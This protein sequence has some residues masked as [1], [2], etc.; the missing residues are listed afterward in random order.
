MTLLTPFR[1]ILIRHRAKALYDVFLP[2]VFGVGLSVLLLA[3]KR[4]VPIFGDK[5]YLS[6][7]QTLLTILGGF[8]IAALVLITTDGGNSL[9]SK[10]VGGAYPPRLPNER[11]PLSRRRFLGYLFGYLSTASIAMV[12][13]SLIANLIARQLAP[14][15]TDGARQ[16]LKWVFV[17]GFNVWLAH[18]TVSTLLGLFY[19]TERLQMPDH[20]IAPG[21]TP[22][23]P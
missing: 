22:P 17:V 19:F 3:L 20:T 4:P 2:L 7:L 5:G 8:F 14:E 23:Q 1:Y 16:A 10:P 6:Q 9:L 21:G 11:A 12:A 18:L 15:I 13:L